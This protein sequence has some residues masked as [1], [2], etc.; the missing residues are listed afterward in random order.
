[1]T[2]TPRLCGSAGRQETCNSVH[3]FAE[4]DGLGDVPE[5]YEEVIDSKLTIPILNPAQSL[6]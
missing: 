1:M 5:S 6:I 4:D 2:K 3:D